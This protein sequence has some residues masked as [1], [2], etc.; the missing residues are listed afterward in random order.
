MSVS[1]RLCG[2]ILAFDLLSTSARIEQMF[3]AIS[4]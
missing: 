4:Q 2:L 1:V 3:D